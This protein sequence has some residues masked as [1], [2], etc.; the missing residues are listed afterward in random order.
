[1]PDDSPLVEAS[2]GWRRSLGLF[3]TVP[4][5]LSSKFRSLM[6]Q[7]GERLSLRSTLRPSHGG[8]SDRLIALTREQVDGQWQRLI[9]G[10]VSR[11]VV[12]DWARPWVEGKIE[13]DPADDKM[14][15]IGLQYLHGYSVLRSGTSEDGFAR[16]TEEMRRDLLWWRERCEQVDSGRVMSAGSVTRRA[17]VSVSARLSLEKGIPLGSL[18]GVLGELDD[19]AVLDVEFLVE[20]GARVL[21]TLIDADEVLPVLAP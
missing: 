11:E 13:A 3:R 21:R 20:D 18:G 1:M 14:A 16:S 10:A 5:T 6:A 15:L 12:F 8:C 4:R 7:H 17:V 2:F 9:E 19:G